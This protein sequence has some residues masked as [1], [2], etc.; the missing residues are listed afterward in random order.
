MMATA[1]RT[2]S[3]LLLA[4]AWPPSV[5][6]A[7]ELQPITLQLRWLHQFQFSGYHMAK[8]KGFYR[9]EGLDVT[10]VPGGPGLAP[11]YEVLEGRAHYG[12]GNI[13][14][15][16]LF[17]EGK[18]LVALAALYQHSPSILLVRQDSDIYNVRDLRGKRIMLFPGHD[19]PELLAMLRTQGL[20]SEDIQRQDTSTD[21]NDLI[22]GNTDAFN[23]YLTNEPYF[24]EEQGVG[25]RIINP[26]D[27]GIDFYS[28][29]LFTT[30][31]ELRNHPERVAAFRR[32]SL[33]GWSYAL[34]YPEETIQVLA[35][36]YGVH[37]SFNHLRYEANLVR[38]MVLPEL[39]EL[40]YMSEQRWL[41]IADQLAKL[42]VIDSDYSLT[43]FLYT[44]DNG[45]DWD[46]WAGWIAGS[47][48]LLL[49]L[50][51]LT[52]GLLLINRRLQFE[53]KER[54][55]AEQ[56]ARHLSLHD[57]L[58]GL[59]NRALLMDRLD[60][61]CKRLQREPGHPALLFIDLDGFKAVNDNCGH[62]AG[63]RLLKEISG[64][65]S[66]EVRSTDT[67]SRYGGD[68]F[69]VLL[70]SNASTEE[71][72]TIGEKLRAALD[73]PHCCEGKSSPVS[74]SIGMV[75][76][77]AGDTPSSVLNKAD[78]AMYRVKKRG[79]NGVQDF[80]QL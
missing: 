43:G 71:M 57:P 38:E 40:G 9:D 60:M 28:D 13:E 79:K 21:I 14:V 59:P 48:L 15:L 25:S 73:T 27:Y 49:V 23:G 52:L 74:A 72:H 67:V 76:L 12:V 51:G 42:G 3:L 61:L 2:I 69:V 63:D 37:K 7:D 65:L 31:S 33:K 18:P 56:R 34:N 20:T 68:E 75:H 8:E 55:K 19:D 29:L 46:R 39:V 16:S 44:T 54:H 30:Q 50:A 5:W 24:M 41:S 53:V 45:I 78:Q 66:R 47:V 6:A 1:V 22:K 62:E 4:L 36:R 26:R 70:E 17:L 64:R 11:A 58:T 80:D 32:A 10:I 35:T 77:R